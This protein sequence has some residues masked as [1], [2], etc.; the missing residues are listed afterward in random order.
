MI[1]GPDEIRACPRCGCLVKQ[2]TLSSGNSFGGV[3]WTDGCA[4][5][6][7]LPDYPVVVKCRDCGTYF[8]LREAK[9]KAKIDTYRGQW[10]PGWANPA[11]WEHVPYAEQ[12]PAQDLSAAIQQGLGSDVDK[13]RYRRIH[14][15]WCAN[16]P[17]R[18]GTTPPPDNVVSPELFA[19]N[20]AALEAL[21]DKSEPSQCLQLAELAR[22]TGRFPECLALLDELPEEYARAAGQLRQLALAGDRLVRQYTRD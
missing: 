14:L 4:E 19:A 22:E 12:L 3:F 8:W 11:K 6:P 20:A 1:P 13:E 15:W 9:L 18:Y 16:S 5:C 2:E 17:H 10:G 21:L 7:M